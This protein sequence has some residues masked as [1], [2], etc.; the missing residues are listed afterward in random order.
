MAIRWEGTIVNHETAW[1][2][3]TALDGL[4]PLDVDIGGIRIRELD[5]RAEHGLR[6]VKLQDADLHHGDLRRG[7]PRSRR[8]ARGEQDADSCERRAPNRSRH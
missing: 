2:R 1:L 8:P 5:A 7:E 4:E 3:W 6:A